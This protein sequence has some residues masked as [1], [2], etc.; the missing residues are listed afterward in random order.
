MHKTIAIVL[1]ISV[2]VV[3]DI[4]MKKPNPPAV[5]LPIEPPEKPIRPIVRPVIA[6]VVYQD[7][8][9]NTNYTSNC[10]QYITLL[11]QKDEE[12]AQLRETLSSL[13]GKE[14]TKL[15]EKLQKEYKEGLEKFEN[16]HHD[17]T[18]KSTATL[19]NKP[20]D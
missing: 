6:P 8:Y 10:E 15:Q 14:Q 4:S 13:K 11:Q 2:N 12:I 18:T 16:R 5:T 19:F 3:A 1:F 7:N 17:S 20:I 9:Y